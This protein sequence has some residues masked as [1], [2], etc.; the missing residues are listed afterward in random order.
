MSVVYF[1]LQHYTKIFL[2]FDF[3]L[4]SSTKRKIKVAFSD[5]SSLFGL[6]PVCPNSAGINLCLET[7]PGPK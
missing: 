7:I 4:L 5:L 2:L 3:I 6:L 1:N